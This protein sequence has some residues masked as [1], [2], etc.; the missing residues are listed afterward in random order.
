MTIKLY[1]TIDDSPSMHMDKKVAF[2]KSKNI[3]AIFYARGEYIKKYPEQI[4]NA[5]KNGFL[6]GNH[7]YTHPYFSE[8]RIEECFDE[9]LKTEK[10]INKC[11]TIKE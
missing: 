10:L 6:I 9:I 8:I 1:L 2:L 11:L 3:P 4:V 7:S 5:I